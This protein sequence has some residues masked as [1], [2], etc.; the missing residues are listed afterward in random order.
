MQS[1]QNSFKMTVAEFL[2]TFG[3]YNTLTIVCVVLYYPRIK[4]THQNFWQY[5]TLYNE[6]I[7]EIP[8]TLKSHIPIYSY[9]SIRLPIY[10]I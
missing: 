8:P 3:R 9:K 7:I 10:P 4:F 2:P 5:T 6:Q 1:V